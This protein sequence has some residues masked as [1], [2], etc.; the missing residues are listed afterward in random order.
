MATRGGHDYDFVDQK[1]EKLTCIICIKVV[2]D[3]HLTGC[4]GQIFCASCLS[5][6][7]EKAKKPNCPHCRAGGDEFHHI[8]DKRAKRE[9][10]ALQMRCRNK[11]QGCNWIGELTGVKNHLE[12]K[13]GCGYVVVKCP[14]GCT[15]LGP[16][17][18]D[19][20][21][22]ELSKHLKDDCDRRPAVCK[23]CD[24][25]DKYNK[26]TYHEN[27][28]CPEKPL[29]CPNQCGVK[30]IKR[31][32]LPTHKGMCPLQSVSCPFKNGGC[33]VKIKRKDLDEHITAYTQQHLLQ[34]FQR[35]DTLNQTLL[36]VKREITFLR[37]T[38]L[39]KEAVKVS[40]D[41]MSTCLDPGS[42]G[43]SRVLRMTDISKY[44]ENGTTWRSPSVPL[45]NDPLVQLRLLVNPCVTEPKMDSRTCL[46]IEV[47]VPP[48]YQI[49]FGYYG[50]S[51]F[52]L[53]QVSLSSK[54]VA[55]EQFKAQEMDESEIW[56]I[57]I[58]YWDLKQS[59]DQYF[60]RKKVFHSED[61]EKK[62][63]NDSFVF[64]INATK[65][66]GWSIPVL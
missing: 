40:L 23:Y 28:I 27:H 37:Q 38:E 50:V 43:Q 63:L 56:M 11:K 49:W 12:S 3:P 64:K 16:T 29:Q 61:L 4:C 9:V 31:K 66:E 32:D 25:K 30:H 6:W 19:L 14:N 1:L 60:Q 58:T 47:E 42:N 62:L 15:H 53:D 26:V 55:D 52:L 59:N 13:D 2:R 33:S 46:T 24:F 35:T 17:I 7:T 34:T 18:N 57:N 8:L 41:C 51:I 5:H 48:E 45:Q 20:Q 36:E 65:T 10:D 22:R 39:N 54:Q 21:R 44:K